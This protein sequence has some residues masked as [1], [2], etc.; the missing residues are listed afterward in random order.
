MATW[1]V[2]AGMVRSGS[3]V[4]YQLASEVVKKYLGGKAL[5]F[6]TP[7]T[8]PSL[9]NTYASTDDTYV[10]KIHAFSREIA[11][12]AATREAHVLYISRD[13]RDVTVSLMHKLHLSFWEVLF[14]SHIRS[15]LRHY[16]QWNTIDNVLASRYETTVDDLSQEAHRI[17]RFLGV[18]LP[19]S[20]AEEIARH[21]SL[22]KQQSRIQRGAPSHD[23]RSASYSPHGRDPASELHSNHI[24]SGKNE[25]WREALSPFQL[26]VLEHLAHEWMIDRG[27]SLSQRAAKRYMAAIAHVALSSAARIRSAL[28][29]LRH[30][31]RDLWK[32]KRLI[33]AITGH[34]RG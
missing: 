17:A 11:E 3:T 14:H 10:V 33:E 25:Q 31:R 21:H 15:A 4:Q 6:V 20:A 22:E 27:Y 12:L 16:H 32:V 1:I 18:D 28:R 5:G 8:F 23:E 2:C 7:S 26:A 29:F 30:P 34:A 13:I 19:P 24:H 9:Y